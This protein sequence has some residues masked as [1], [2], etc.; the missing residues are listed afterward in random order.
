MPSILCISEKKEKKTTETE[1][2]TNEGCVEN[3]PAIGKTGS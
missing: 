3:L 1:I 2:P